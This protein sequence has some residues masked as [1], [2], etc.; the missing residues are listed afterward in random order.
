MWFCGNDTRNDTNFSD[1]SEDET[2]SYSKHLTSFELIYIVTLAIMAA[3]GTLGN[4]LASFLICTYTV[5]S[6]IFRQ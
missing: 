3:T 5:I 1:D 6:C 2:K 4:F